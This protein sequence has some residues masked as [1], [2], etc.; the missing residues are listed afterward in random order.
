LEKVK[1]EFS[2]LELLFGTPFHEGKVEIWDAGCNTTTDPNFKDDVLGWNGNSLTYIDTSVAIDPETGTAME[3]LLYQYEVVPPGVEFEFNLTGQNLS[4]IE[5]GILLLA[6]EGFNSGI[7]PIQVGG[8]GG[9]G[10]GHLK[11]EPTNIYRLEAS[12]LKGWVTGMINNFGETTPE[13]KT[14]KKMDAGYFALPRLTSEEKDKLV[15]D[16]K[17]ALLGQIGK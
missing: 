15:K 2:W 10:F 4:R 17:N 3:H 6:L 16:V 1:A 5:L 14:S 9:R 13:Q 12:G 7:Y 8:R 11:W